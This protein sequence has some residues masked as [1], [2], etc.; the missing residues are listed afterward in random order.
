[1][2]TL[3]QV[4]AAVEAHWPAGSA[5]HWDRVGLVAGDRRARVTRLLLAVDPVRATAAEAVSAGCELLICHH[6]LLLRGVSA[7]PEH[8]V[9]GAVLAPL[10]RAGSALL[11]VHTNGD[12]PDDGTSAVLAKVLGLRG[13]RPITPGSSAEIGIGRVGELPRSERL[14]QLAL[15]LAK[16]LPS[17][18]QGVRVSGEFDRKV[19]TVAL[20]AGAGGDLL[21]AAEVLGA[22]VYVTSDLRHHPASGFRELDGP[23]LID[24]SHWA[25]E[26][27]WLD[28]AAELLRADLPDVEVLVSEINTDP[29][30][31]VVQQ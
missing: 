6:P 14:G 17:T 30:D 3:A 28:R 4:E 29:W 9:P 24:I 11:T 26:W 13:T 31:F 8:S 18:A 27:L 15:R 25:A 12:S 2:S 16:L 7:L 23:A 19:R 22:D 21:D 20:C 10:I 5:E 1:M